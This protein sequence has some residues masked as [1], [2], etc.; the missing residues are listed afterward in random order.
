MVSQVLHSCAHSQQIHTRTGQQ[1]GSL[2]KG[3]DTKPDH[4]SLKPGTYMGE[5]ENSLLKVVIST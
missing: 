4:Y 1:D 5:G 3:D 2:G